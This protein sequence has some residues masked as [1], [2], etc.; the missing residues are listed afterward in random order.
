M[1]TPK[2][3]KCRGSGKALG[4]GCGELVFRY[5][6]CM[7]RTCFFE[8]LNETPEG[9][10]YRSKLIKK[11]LN[12]VREE[13]KVKRKYIKWEEKPT[14]EM[15]T[16]LQDN[17]VNPYIRLRDI[18]NGYRCISSDGVIEHAGHCFSVGSCPGLRFNIMNIHGQQHAANVHK[19]GDFDNY[20]I[21]LIE[22]HGLAY[23]EE[24]SRLKIKAERNKILDRLEVIRIGKTYE[25][26]T[27]KT[28][29]C[30]SHLEFENYKNII[31]K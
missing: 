25:Y 9:N 21:G 26:L 22:R 1:I 15:I 27:K 28:I 13:K 24:L 8:W 16:Y 31:N 20:R 7:C 14:K 6:L 12:K 29:W 10:E 5:K 19:H 18:E 2:K 30:F 11:T 23:F 4:Y 3:N 17:I